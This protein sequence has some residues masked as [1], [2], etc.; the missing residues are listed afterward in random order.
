[1]NALVQ[2]ICTFVTSSIGRKV[3]VAITGACLVLFLAGHLVGN[4][5]IYG[6]PELINTYAHGLHS[7]PPAALWGIRIG[8]G[9]IFAI[10]VW[11][12]IQLK[13]ENKA[14]R[15]PYAC[16]NTITA[17][18]SSRYMI[19]SGITVLLFLIYHLY[20]YTLRVGYDPALY[21]TTIMDG[22]ETFNVHQMIVDGFSNVGCSVIY[23]IAVAML[24]THLRHGVQSIFQSV[25]L[26]S[27]KIRPVYNL[28][29]IAYATI[30]C[31]G[32]ISVPVA[33]LLGII[34]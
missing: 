29:A 11:I 8:L 21:Q 34:K 9:I 1:M 13:M 24:F 33:V 28:I 6:N 32:F 22:V 5:L 17:T 3:I 25:G 18:L 27:R 26:S 7:M 14:A 20:Q 10:H 19:Y 12:T 31:A 2:T 4:L 30:I 23:I 15:E 16:Q